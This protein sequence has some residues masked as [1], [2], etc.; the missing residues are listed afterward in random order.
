[1]SD[2]QLIMRLYELQAEDVAVFDEDG[3]LLNR[4]E[5]MNYVLAAEANR[6]LVEQTS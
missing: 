6:N 2:F 4:V 5:V 3:Y 1:M